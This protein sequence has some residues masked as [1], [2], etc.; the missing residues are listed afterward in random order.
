MTDPIRDYRDGPALHIVRY[1]KPDVVYLYLTAEMALRYKSGDVFVKAIKKTAPGCIIE[2][3]KS[4]ITDPSD[5]DAFSDL[6]KILTGIHERHS[7][8]EI[9]LNVSS[10]TP[11]MIASLCIG[12]TSLPFSTTPVQVK[13]FERRANADRKHL[14]DNDIEIALECNEDDYNNINRCVEPD[15]FE[16]KRLSLKS[17]LSSLLE[18]YNFVGAAS[19]AESED[20]ISQKGRALIKLANF[21]N[22]YDIKNAEKIA[23]ELNLLDELFPIK[24]A[25]AKKVCEFYNILNIRASQ[26]EYADFILRVKPLSE[27][28]AMEFCAEHI[29]IDKG[30]YLIK[31]T[32]AL[33]QY[34]DT[35]YYNQFDFAK[36][37]SIAVLICVLRFD[38][39]SDIADSLEEINN[40]TALRNK[41]AH[42]L[43]MPERI[44][45]NKILKTL[46][47]L[48]K[49]K[50]EKEV[51]AEIYS[52]Y[53]KINEMIKEEC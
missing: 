29:H 19:V 50:Y 37:V 9:L 47:E 23:R 5:F 52:V 44:N 7:G 13:A 26:K 31:Q 40:L 3:I 45:V 39:K 20:F 27:F 11:Q 28:L 33:K 21:R 46:K 2:V 22:G 51:K 42:S 4:E 12:A 6:Y 18:N 14:N 8:S 48:I 30:A 38:N 35:H 10:G 43:E 15:I 36:P 24:N 25:S 16:F 17:R 49:K 41:I 53:D 34:L 32:S 1:Y